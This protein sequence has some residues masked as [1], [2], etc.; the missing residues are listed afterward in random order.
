MPAPSL[1]ENSLKRN[2]ALIDLIQQEIDAANACR[3]PDQQQQPIQ[4]IAQ[5]TREQ[6][7]TDCCD[8]CHKVW[9]WPVVRASVLLCA[10]SRC[11]RK[12]RL[13]PRGCAN[14]VRLTSGSTI[15]KHALPPST[16]PSGPRDTS[17]CRSASTPPRRRCA[18]AIKLYCHTDK[19]AICLE[20]ALTTI[21]NTTRPSMS[22]VCAPPSRSFDA[23]QIQ[24]RNGA[25]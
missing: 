2:F 20:S 24:R 19:T 23:V 6:D 22:T 25:S 13:S 15:A 8:A 17:V 11:E 1:L 7:C 12:H 16:P 3:D 14:T 5:L 10:E 9:T 21:T 18:P 4:S